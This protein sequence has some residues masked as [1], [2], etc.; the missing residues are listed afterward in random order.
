[1]MLSIDATSPFGGLT[2]GSLTMLALAF[3]CT[4]SETSQGT[5]EDS[6]HGENSVCVTVG[7]NPKDQHRAAS[8]A[9]ELHAFATTSRKSS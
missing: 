3:P 5:V 2:A 1:M 7:R 4:A 8:A 6:L 9:E